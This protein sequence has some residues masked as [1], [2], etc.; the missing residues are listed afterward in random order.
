MLTNF[1]SITEE[2]TEEEKK[3]V[4]VLIKGFSTKGKENPITG[5]EVV[6]AINVYKKVYG[7]KRDFTEP[8][9]RKICNFIRVKGI[10]PLIAT[11]NGYYISY[12]REEI[13]A[14]I[15]SLNERAMAIQASAEGLKKFIQ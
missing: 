9:L 3:L 4:P 5:K 14:Q 7:L 6:K 8:R 15:D 13:R 11:S 2:L 12:D 1:E 10:L